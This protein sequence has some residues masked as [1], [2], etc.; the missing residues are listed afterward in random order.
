MECCIEKLP[1]L[2]NKYYITIGI[3]DKT[4]TITLDY[5]ASNTNTGLTFDILPNLVSTTMGQRTPICHF[6]SRWL[7]DGKQLDRT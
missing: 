1:L 6:D 2:A 3:Y 4:R 7:I 5:W